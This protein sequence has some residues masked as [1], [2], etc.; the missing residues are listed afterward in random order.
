MSDTT[1][2]DLLRHGEPQGGRAYRGH[3]IDDPLSEK[4]WQQMWDAVGEQPPWQQIISSPMERCL[5]FAEA[6]MDSY[7]IPCETEQD[8][9]EVGFGHWEGKT[10]EQVQQQYADEYQQFYADPV[11]CRPQG[12]EPLD[13][14]ISRVV[15]AYQRQ[16]ETYPGQHILIVA[17]AGVIRALIAHALHAEPVGLYRIKVNNAGISRIQH[18]Q[19]S[20]T[21]L[22]HNVQLAD[23]QPC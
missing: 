16:L 21:L 4:G 12:A 18:R 19:G 9:R 15:H 10:V 3:G 11:N 20:N 17:H 22:Y 14:F 8:F 6:L 23:M 1:T 2:I 5:A 13:Q 7:A